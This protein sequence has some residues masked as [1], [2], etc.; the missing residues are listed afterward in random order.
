MDKLVVILKE[1]GALVKK[2]PFIHCG[3]C[4]QNVLIGDYLDHVLLF[5]SCLAQLISSIHGFS[6]MPGAPSYVE[7]AHWWERLT[8]RIF[9]RKYDVRLITKWKGLPLSALA[10]PG[11]EKKP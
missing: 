6:S 1:D 2:G 8:Q 9:L 4:R 7:P 10:L 11:L 3:G 5:Q